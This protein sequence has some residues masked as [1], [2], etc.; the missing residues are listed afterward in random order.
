MSPTN[1][2]GVGDDVERGLLARESEKVK[3]D[4]GDG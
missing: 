2:S 4:I 3:K 1:F